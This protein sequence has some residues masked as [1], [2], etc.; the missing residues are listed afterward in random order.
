MH[1]PEFVVISMTRKE[2]DEYID[3]YHPKSSKQIINEYDERINQKQAATLFGVTTAT[4]IRWQNKGIIPYNRVGRTVFYYK[5]QL[6]EVAR[7]KPSLLK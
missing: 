5:S 4:I 7:K 3:K 2:L 6:L 1:K